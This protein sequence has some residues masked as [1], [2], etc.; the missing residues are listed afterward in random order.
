MVAKAEHK[1]NFNFVYTFF[2]GETYLKTAENSEMRYVISNTT[3]AGIAY[4]IRMHLL[5]H[6]QIRFLQNLQMV[7]S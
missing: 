6:L 1:D 4:R 5:T 3:D 7:K 2:D